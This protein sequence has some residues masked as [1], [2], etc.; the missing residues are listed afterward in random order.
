[1]VTTHLDTTERHNARGTQGGACVT[2]IPLQN[3]GLDMLQSTEGVV[4][5]W[6]CNAGSRARCGM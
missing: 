4:A 2:F 5:D 1:M 3:N 6:I